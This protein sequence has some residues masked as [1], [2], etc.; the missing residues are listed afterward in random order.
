MNFA[1]ERRTK[2]IAEDRK[3][4]QRCLK[5]WTSI[6]CLVSC[7]RSLVQTKQLSLRILV[8]QTCAARPIFSQFVKARQ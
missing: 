4:V 1:T 3:K 6:F 8:E 5:T 7:E 2:K